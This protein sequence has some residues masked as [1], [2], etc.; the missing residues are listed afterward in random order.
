MLSCH[1]MQSWDRSRSPRQEAQP[2][3]QLISRLHRSPRPSCAPTCD[4]V[5]AN[6]DYLR[7]KKNVHVGSW[8]GIRS[9]DRGTRNEWSQSLARYRLAANASVVQTEFRRCPVSYLLLELM[10]GRW[11]RGRATDG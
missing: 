6:C 2:R 10:A 9:H 8:H 5:E 4:L 11:H 1:Q 3:V 7:C